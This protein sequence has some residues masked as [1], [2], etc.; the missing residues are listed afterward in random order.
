MGVAGVR[1]AGWSSGAQ[2]QGCLDRRS[3]LLAPT[4]VAVQGAVTPVNYWLQYLATGFM[5][6]GSDKEPQPA[7]Q[8]QANGLDWNLYTAHIFRHPVDIALA[9]GHKRTI[10]VLLVSEPREH[11]VMYKLVSI[12]MVD[13]AVER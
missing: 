7:G 4:G 2:G 11:E 1:P 8:R 3:W 12:P 10:L 9:A 6:I 13:A 5:G